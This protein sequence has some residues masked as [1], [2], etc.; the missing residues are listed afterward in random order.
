MSEGFFWPKTW[1]DAFPLATWT[2]FI[3][4][5]GFEGIASLVHGE[6]VP[7]AVSFAITLGLLAML[8]HGR[9]WLEKLHPN[10]LAGAIVVLIAALAIW[11]SITEGQL[12]RISWESVG[13]ASFA[14]TIIAAAVI[15]LLVAGKRQATVS[16]APLVAGIDGQTRL[17]IGQLL[18]F[19]IS[20]AAFWVLDRLLDLS[21]SPEITD[22]FEDGQ[23]TEA[24]HKSRE[25]YVGYVRQELGPGTHRLSTY[26]TLMH[27]AQGEAERELEQT[28]RD[29]RRADLDPLV[30]RKYRISERQFERAVQFIRSERRQLKEKLGQARHSLSE[31]I[32]ARE[33]MGRG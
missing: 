3:F 22:A 18:D 1:R 30:L 25:F 10:W 13:V 14:G 27:S 31:R 19:A 12:P 21:E 4:A 2:I 6:W 29:Q 5:A 11:P 28:P 32:S 20:E 9:A 17:E 15:I 33:T 26:L 16:P 8:L 7:S 24:A 23:D